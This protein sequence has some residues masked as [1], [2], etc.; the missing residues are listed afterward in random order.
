MVSQVLEIFKG[1]KEFTWVDVC[2][3]IDFE[4]ENSGCT[5]V[6]EPSFQPEVRILLDDPFSIW[7][8]RDKGLSCLDMLSANHINHWPNDFYETLACT[9]GLLRGIV[10]V[11]CAGF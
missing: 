6:L 7:A 9:V 4:A 5:Y 8:S 2:I 3:W 11:D 1:K 10:D